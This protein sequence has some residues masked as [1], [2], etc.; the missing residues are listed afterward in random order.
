MKIAVIGSGAM[1]SLF[2]GRLAETGHTVM[3]FDIFEEH[4]KRI[5][6][7]GLIIQDAADGKERTVQPRATTDPME[8]AGY[9]IYILF[10]KSTATEAAGRQFVKIVGPD[11]VV[12]TLQNGYGNE[13]I[14]RKIFGPGRTAAG[15]TS[16][17]ATFL[18]PG[19]IRHA[20]KGPTHLCMSDR[21]NEKLTAFVEA[22]E[23]AGFE[24]HVEENIQDLIWSKL[25]IN[26]GIN[27]LT[28]VTGVEN[29]RL[30]DFEGTKA[31]M[32]DLVDE[33]L[34]V[35]QAKGITLTYSDAFQMTMDVAKK[36]AA[37][38]SS[39]LQDFDKGRKTEIDFI[40]GAVVRE[41]ENLGIGVPVNKTMTHL[42]KM[43][44]AREVKI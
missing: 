36:T 20:G 1:G 35:V 11:A 38:R 16:Q 27:A 26:V 13:E 44:E 19:K 42:V 9:D 28:A 32:K 41:A 6:Q 15:V 10:V 3:L 39:M 2:G 43:M 14:L 30:L 25:V 31:V 22:L 24:A 8:A 23:K 4:V 29:G 12:I 5:N 33:V 18:G 37:N 21:K 40:N 34:Q 7:Q 17:G